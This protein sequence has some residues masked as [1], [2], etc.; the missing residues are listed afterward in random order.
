MH[1]TVSSFVGFL[2][3]TR[4][5]ERQPTFTR[6]TQWSSCYR[7]LQKSG[8]YIHTIIVR[9]NRICLFITAEFQHRCTAFRW[10][11]LIVVVWLKKKSPLS[12]HSF[13]AT[14]RA[15]QQNRHQLVCLRPSP[16]AFGHVIV[17]FCYKTNKTNRTSNWLSKHLC[18]F[19]WMNRCRFHLIALDFRGQPTVYISAMHAWVFLILSFFC[20]FLFLKNRSLPGW[21]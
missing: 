6:T 5:S 11:L 16:E 13:W 14:L 18:W 1:G 12:S 21:N 10:R 8:E 3:P 9:S 7:Y 19:V 2:P 20:W 4:R 17:R 15:C